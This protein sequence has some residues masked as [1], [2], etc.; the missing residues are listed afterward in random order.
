[1]MNNS[2][3]I[4]LTNQDIETDDAI[5]A[6]LE[7]ILRRTSDSSDIEALFQVLKA[8]LQSNVEESQSFSHYSNKGN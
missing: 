6:E 3:D 2:A 5:M 4:Q 7:G 8:E 1:M